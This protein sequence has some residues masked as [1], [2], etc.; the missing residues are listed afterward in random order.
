MAGLPHMLEEEG[1]LE[2]FQGLER[3][4]RAPEMSLRI[5]MCPI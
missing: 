4:T 3:A 5:E 1:T 2:G